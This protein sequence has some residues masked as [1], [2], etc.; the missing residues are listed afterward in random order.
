MPGVDIHAGPSYI[1]RVLS[2]REHHGNESK[3]RNEFETG[4]G[5]ALQG[6]KRKRRA[7]ARLRFNDLGTSGMKTMNIELWSYGQCHGRLS[8]R[9]NN[10]AATVICGHTIHTLQMAMPL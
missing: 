5:A 9:F 8:P 1:C 3:E 4:G 6:W 10:R 7:E 2:H